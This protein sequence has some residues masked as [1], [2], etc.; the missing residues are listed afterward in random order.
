MS[1]TR[2]ALGQA[3]ELIRQDKMAEAIA[4]LKPIT[5]AEPQNADAWWLLA[6]AHSE[7]R[8]ARR[9][10]VTVLTINPNHTKARELLEKLN[11][12]YPPRDDELIMLMDLPEA[13]NEPPT[14]VAPAAKETRQP[15]P[16]E[17]DDLF[18]EDIFGDLEQES[19][20]PPAKGR[21]ERSTSEIDDLFA[22]PPAGGDSDDFELDDDDENPFADL[23]DDNP[24]DR[25]K[26]SR[27]SGGGRRIVRLL[28][29]ILLVGICLVAA[30]ILLG[31]GGGEET[32]P[33]AADPADLT[34]LAADAINAENAANLTDVQSILQADAQQ[35]LGATSQV[36][37]TQTAAGNGLVIRACVEPSPNLPQTA[38]EAMRL[39]AL[40]VGSTPSIQADLAL[41]GVSLED[42]SRNNDT[43]Y[44]ALSPMAAVVA[45]SANPSDLNAFRA[46]W[47]VEN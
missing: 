46:S 47:Q 12:L 37:F 8:D 9:A 7:A 20:P 38:V 33:V 19:A 21:K 34:E 35:Q 25:A 1:T 31:N 23:L 24:A 26:K 44:R 16:V 45:Y 36:I 29:L 4:I 15:D 28:V 14:I 13:D 6:N 43:L 3:F 32:P 41:V 30:F 5:E 11:D 22:V 17:E 10:L 18:G 40:R 27:R 2:Q 39:A 42:C